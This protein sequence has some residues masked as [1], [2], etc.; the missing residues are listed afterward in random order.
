MF[1]S[2]CKEYHSCE[3]ALLIVVNDMLWAMKCTQVAALVAHD[4]ST[5]FDTV[6]HMIPLRV[7]ENN[8]GIRDDA[9]EWL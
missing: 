6:N 3:T 7:L 2:A 4:L 5:L 8:F 1:Q 9:L